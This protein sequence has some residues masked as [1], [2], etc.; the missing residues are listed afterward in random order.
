MTKA[1]GGIPPSSAEILAEAVKWFKKAYRAG[2]DVAVI[3]FAA[4]D[5]LGRLDTI[6]KG[7]T[8]YMHNKPR[9]KAY[10]RL[11]LQRKFLRAILQ[12]NCGMLN[13]QDTSTYQY[14]ALVHILCAVPPN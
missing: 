3:K 14:H 7:N 10:E 9:G 1:N 8:R 6:T 12:I 5:I 13:S 4:Q 2:T 11:E